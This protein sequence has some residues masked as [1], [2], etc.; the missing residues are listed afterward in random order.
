MREKKII[1][2]LTTNYDCILQKHF[3]IQAYTNKDCQS[4]WYELERE[5]RVIF[6]IHGDIKKPDS[7]IFTHK[8][9][10]D[11]YHMRPDFVFLLQLLLNMYTFI[12][13]GCS[14]ADPFFGEALDAIA[15]FFVNQKRK[16][17]AILPNEPYESVFTLENLRGIRV[18]PYT[19]DDQ[20]DHEEINELLNYLYTGKQITEDVLK[21][22]KTEDVLKKLNINY[23]DINKWQHV[24]HPPELLQED[25]KDCIKV[26]Y[27]EGSNSSIH[28]SLGK[29]KEGETYK[30]SVWFKAEPKN[31]GA[32]F[33]GDAVGPDPYDNSTLNFAE[34]T[35][36]WQKIEVTLKFTHDD[37]C[38]V[39]LYGSRG[40]GKDGDFVLYKDLEI[41]QI[42]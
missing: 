1:P 22:P 15:A 3:G 40:K 12:F 31:E 11:L 35:E 2:I 10:Q 7:I 5:N 28:I 41:Y 33:L 16:H 20:K 25:G 42:L 4:V 21:E 19:P 13:L 32:I 38:L 27:K 36:D 26:R 37:G 9:Y 29:F 23:L 8:D 34:G 30:A 17:Y 39:F 6:K 14:L 24:G 18:I